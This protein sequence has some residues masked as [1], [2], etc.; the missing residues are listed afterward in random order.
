MHRT[1]VDTI[2]IAVNARPQRSLSRIENLR[3]GSRNPGRN[4]DRQDYSQS[5]LR[6]SSPTAGRWQHDVNPLSN[7]QLELSHHNTSRQAQMELAL[8]RHPGT[9]NAAKRGRR[10]EGYCFSVPERN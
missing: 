3:V 7:Y 2:D 5:R 10:W 9:T 4:A 8:A 6:I 1:S